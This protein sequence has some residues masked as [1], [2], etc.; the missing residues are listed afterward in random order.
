MDAT[1]DRDFVLEYVNALAQL[2]IHLSRLCEELILFASQEYG[3]VLLPEAFSTGSSAMP[4]KKNPDAFELI[5]AKSGTLLGSAQ[6]I[7][8]IQ[9]GLPLAYN[10]DLQEIQPLLFQ[11][12]DIAL[13]CARTAAAAIR[14]LKFRHERMAHAASAGY[15]NAMAA[16]T[17]LV[18]KGV[19]FRSAHEQIARAVRECIVRGCEL[20]GLPLSELQQFAPQADQDLYFA[21][22]PDA[23]LDCHDVFGGTAR[24]RVD[25]AIKAARAKLDHAVEAPHVHA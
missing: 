15:M 7:A 22:T 17:Y 10:K 9:K 21:V 20:H 11:A 3:F 14:N 18:S 2:G 13:A 1:A 23:V 8:I 25:E 5:R 6:G 4:Q 24:H 12:C 19:P 16:A